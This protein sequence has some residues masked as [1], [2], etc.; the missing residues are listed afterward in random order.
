MPAHRSSAGLPRDALLQTDPTTLV[1][2]TRELEAALAAVKTSH[3]R[4][5][6]RRIR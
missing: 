5:L 6:T 1:H 4:K 3:Y 2:V